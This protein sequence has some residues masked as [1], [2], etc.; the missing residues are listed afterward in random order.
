MPFEGVELFE[1]GDLFGIDFDD[2]L[3]SIA[4][5]TAK[6]NKR[7]VVFLHGFDGLFIIRYVVDVD[8]HQATVLDKPPSASWL[9]SPRQCDGRQFKRLDLP[10]CLFARCLPQPLNRR[11]E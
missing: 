10:F 4:R 1:V 7:V 6:A 2:A 11:D 9:K 8:L 3:D 5:G